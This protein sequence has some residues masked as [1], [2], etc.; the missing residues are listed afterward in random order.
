M[1]HNDYK[2][3][4]YQITSIEK[5]NGGEK[6]RVSVQIPKKIGWIER[7]KFSV[8][9]CGQKRVFQLKHLKNDDKFVYFQTEVEL[10]NSALYHYYFSFEANGNFQYYK[11]INKTELC[12]KAKITTNAIIQTYKGIEKIEDENT[13][14]E[15]GMEFRIIYNDIQ[16]VYKIVV[17]GDI[18]GD[19][20]VNQVDLLMLARNKAG[21]IYEKKRVVNEYLRAT[22]ILKNDKAA[23]D[24][25]LFKL[26]RILAKMDKF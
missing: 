21:F 11:K 10:V 19:G 5:F 23:E 8:T 14:L 16:K 17:M 15:T 2:D 22:D 1:R 20:K 12:E 24:K 26:A 18:S 25:D 9:T 4:S 13:K 7:M 3:F 6:F